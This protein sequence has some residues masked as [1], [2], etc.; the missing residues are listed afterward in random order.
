VTYRQLDYWLRTGAITL[1]SDALPGSGHSRS[2]TAE[3]VQRLIEV[4]AMVRSAQE[5]LREFASGMMWNITD[6]ARREPAYEPRT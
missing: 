3:E 5:I 6:Y 2:F 4:S 1:R